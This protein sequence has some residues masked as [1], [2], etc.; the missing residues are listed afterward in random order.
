MKST[1]IT[2]QITYVEPESMKG[3]SACAGVVI[4]GSKTLFIDVGLVDETEAFIRSEK[5][6]SAIVTHYHIDHAAWLHQAKAVGGIDLYA[7]ESEIACLDGWEGFLAHTAGPLGKRDF[8]QSWIKSNTEFRPI[9][10]LKPYTADYLPFADIGVD[11]EVIPTPGHSPGHSSFYFPGEQVLFC[12]DLGADR[13]GPW[14]G[15]PDCDLQEFVNSLLRIKELPIKLLLTSHGGVIEE[16]IDDVWNRCIDQ[17]K[18][19][20]EKVRQALDQG[21]SRV[22][23]INAGIFY[24]NPQAIKGSIG[25]VALMMEGGTYDQHYRFLQNGGLKFG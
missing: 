11:M 2:D 9:E 19:R 22:E 13:F 7:P 8:W 25:E 10:G 5:P 21:L 23:T 3:F 14:Y 12:G 6:S 16:G 15:W 4:K 1:A 17:I 24:D 18:A 20:E